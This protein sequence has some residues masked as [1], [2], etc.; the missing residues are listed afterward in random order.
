MDEGN[1]SGPAL[2]LSEVDAFAEAAH[3]GQ[4]RDHGQPY[5]SHPRAVRAILE[6]EFPEPVDDTTLAI[7]L[8]HDVLE[9][10]DIHP[11]ILL[12]RYGQDVQEGVT[13]LSWHLKALGIDRNEKVYWSGIRNGPRAVRLVKAADRIH[14]LRDAI[15]NGHE[16]MMSKYLKETPTDLLP[17]LRDAG[18]MWGVEQLEHLVGELKRRKG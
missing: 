7:A 16:R 2:D 5:I 3:A 15:A 11:T 8:L 17:I 4:T 12:E 9:D 14:N 18:E 10:C 6:D 13:L 1:G